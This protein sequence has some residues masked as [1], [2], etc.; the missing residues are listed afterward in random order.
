MVIITL[1][2]LKKQVEE[3]FKVIGDHKIN[4]AMAKIL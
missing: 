4:Q 2:N 1:Q 3:I